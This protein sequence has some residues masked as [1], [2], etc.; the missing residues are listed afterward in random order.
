M[1]TNTLL[2]HVRQKGFLGQLLHFV[3]DI[4]HNLDCICQCVNCITLS[5]LYDEMIS[6][7]QLKDHALIK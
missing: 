3:V 5:S 1:V 4:Q 2:N 7:P 6:D